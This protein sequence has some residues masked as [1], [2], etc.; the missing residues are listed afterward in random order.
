MAAVAVFDLVRMEHIVFYIGV[1]AQLLL[2]TLALRVNAGD[3]RVRAFS[4]V[5]IA[6]AFWDLFIALKL[7][8]WSL[9]RNATA[10]AIERAEVFALVVANAALSWF[11]LV[12]PRRRRWSRGRPAVVIA[13]LWGTI[14]LVTMVYP[15]L[16]L[17]I[18][19]GPNHPGPL[20]VIES[21]W[22]IQLLVGAVMCVRAATPDILGPRVVALAFLCYPAVASLSM[23]PHVAQGVS[24]A[25]TYLA[26][27]SAI[28]AVRF[29]LLGVSGAA[30]PLVA[31]YVA[32]KGG[33]AHW[34]ILVA[35]LVVPLMLAGLVEYPFVAAPS[36][37]VGIAYGVS[38]LGFGAILAYGVLRHQLFDID[39]LLHFAVNRSVFATAIAF[40]F[41]VLSESL[42][43][44]LDLESSPAIKVAAAVAIALAVRPFQI[45]SERL[46]FRFTHIDTTPEALASRRKEIYAEAVSA[47]W[48]DGEPGHR[49]R[50]VLD[51]LR[52]RLQ[53]DR[54][55][56]II[57]ESD[58]RGTRMLKG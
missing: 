14:V 48:A 29:V 30:L 5:L 9:E 23:W 20:F 18:R 42:E 39:L 3:I 51:A 57:V 11:L 28:Y 8:A 1:T 31:T 52:H 50:Q 36:W 49:E 33:G 38:A 24:E 35:A 45:M 32:W 22:F 41:L 47:A 7:G 40:A 44:L 4:S 17:D 34:R 21:L 53:L 15:G 6:N 43:G 13:A 19:P 12:Y 27:W 46:A 56:A 16:V 58:A 54:D 26:P 2:A 55:A 25:G 10:E 37:V